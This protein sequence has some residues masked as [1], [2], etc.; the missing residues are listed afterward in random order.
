[1]VDQETR[2]KSSNCKLDKEEL[3]IDYCNARFNQEWFE[4]K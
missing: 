3:K 1:M 2:G 4:N